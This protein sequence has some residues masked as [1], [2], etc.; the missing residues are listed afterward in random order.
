MAIHELKVWPEFFEDLSENNRN[1]E[2]RKDD[3]GFQIGDVLTLRE[4]DPKTDEYTGSF[5]TK[6]V[7]HIVRGGPWLTEGYCALSIRDIQAKDL[8]FIR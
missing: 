1:V 5:C 7:T 6:V 2:L 3:R 4:Y 8:K